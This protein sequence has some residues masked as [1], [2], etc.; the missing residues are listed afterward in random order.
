MYSL[1]AKNIK[2][3]AFVEY[4]GSFNKFTMASISSRNI[5]YVMVIIVVLIDFWN[6]MN[7]VKKKY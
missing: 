3:N 1:Q 4:Q 2:I 6:K 7:D 5:L